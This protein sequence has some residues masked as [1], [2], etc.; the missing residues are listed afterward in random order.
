MGT[1][2]PELEALESTANC[3]GQAG[4]QVVLCRMA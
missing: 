2:S 3:D 4:V 1:M